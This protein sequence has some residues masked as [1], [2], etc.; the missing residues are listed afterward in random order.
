MC[1]LSPLKIFSDNQELRIFL[2]K[3]K[4]WTFISTIINTL[5]YLYDNYHLN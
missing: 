2:N 4:N 3:S 1:I 5:K